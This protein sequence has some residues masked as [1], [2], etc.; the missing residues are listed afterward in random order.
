MSSQCVQLAGRHA[1]VVRT[2]GHGQLAM[3]PS[4]GVG[5]PSSPTSL[6]PLDATSNTP[7]HASTRRRPRADADTRGGT[8]NQTTSGCVVGYLKA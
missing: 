3:A 4:G 1:F 5:R 8:A 7:E 6:A 2:P